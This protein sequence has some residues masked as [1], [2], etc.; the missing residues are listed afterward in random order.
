[1]WGQPGLQSGTLSQRKKLELEMYFRWQS[2]CLAFAKL[3]NQKFT[4][5][6]YCH[7]NTHSGTRSRSLRLAW[8][9]WDPVTNKPQ[10]GSGYDTPLYSKDCSQLSPTFLHCWFHQH[11]PGVQWRWRGFW[12]PLRCLLAFLPWRLQ[13]PE[14]LDRKHPESWGNPQAPPFSLLSSSRHEIC[15]HCCSWTSLKG[16]HVC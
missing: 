3:H 12:K 15:H 16:S 14:A 8:D 13:S 5:Q 11:P 4:D 6:I 9:T 7:P 2:A 10:T 1:M